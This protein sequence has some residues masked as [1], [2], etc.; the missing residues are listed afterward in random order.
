M[1][2]IETVPFRCPWCGKAG[3]T[4]VDCTAGDQEYVEDCWSCCRP[5]VIRVTLDS[6][7]ADACSV[8]VS[9]EGE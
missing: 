7:D 4:A 3:E 1:N 8:S 5:M 9:A 2:P 6:A